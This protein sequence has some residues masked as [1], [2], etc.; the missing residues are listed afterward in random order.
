MPKLIDHAERQEEIATAAWRVILQ[1][2][3]SA[4]SVRTVAAEA[5]LSVGSVRHVF[6]SQTQL[7]A[8]AMELVIDRADAR[9][10]ALPER[11]T[12]LESMED[13]AVELLPLDEERRS[14]MEVYLALFAATGT[15]PKLI[16]TRAEVWGR[17]HAGCRTIVTRLADDESVTEE[18]VEREVVLLHALV[19][20]LAAHLVWQP[21]EVSGA[22]ARKVIIDH[23]HELTTRLGAGPS[24][25]QP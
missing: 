17:V 13:I 10:T 14:E 6:A 1:K 7:L 9:I 15:D 5:G 12:P 22:A 23:L 19:D 3:I 24:G 20:G 11:T 18:Q 2:G 8:F 25:T 4:V 16:D 21:E